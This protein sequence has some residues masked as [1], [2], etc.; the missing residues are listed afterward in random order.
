MSPNVTQPGM[1]QWQKGLMGLMTGSQQYGQN[2]PQAHQA[3]QQLMGSMARPQQPQAAPM[4]MR[5]PMMAVPRMGAPQM[6]QQPQMGM[7]GTQQMGSTSAPA[8]LA[9]WLQAMQGGR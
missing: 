3:M 6:G 7:M 8:S 4:G 1:P 5:R 2:A 9:P